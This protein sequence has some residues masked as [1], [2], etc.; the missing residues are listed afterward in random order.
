M[1]EERGTGEAMEEERE[2]PGKQWRKRERDQGSNGGR[3]RGTGGRNRSPD[4]APKTDLLDN[5]NFN[6][7]APPPPHRIYSFQHNGLY[8]V[9]ICS[10]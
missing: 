7:G 2:G 8:S 9:V 4:E 10:L 5:Y 3:E 1:E 6:A